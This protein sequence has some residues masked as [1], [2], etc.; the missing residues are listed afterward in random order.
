MV[1]K[2]YSF[3]SA[4]IKKNQMTTFIF[5]ILESFSGREGIPVKANYGEK[6]NIEK[7][8]INISKM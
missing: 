3:R 5:N 2:M 8:I 7:K 1:K 4:N 6:V